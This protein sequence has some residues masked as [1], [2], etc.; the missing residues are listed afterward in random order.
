MAE[1][2][3]PVKLYLYDLSHGMAAQLSLSMLGQHFEAIYH[4]GIVVHGKEYFYGQGVMSCVP[5]TSHHGQPMEIVDLGVTAVDKAISDSATVLSTRKGLINFLLT[6]LPQNFMATPLG[7]LLRP[8]VDS[9]FPAAGGGAGPS[10]PQRAKKNRKPSAAARGAAES[11][12]AA[13]NA[14]SNV[15]NNVTATSSEQGLETV[16]GKS[17]VPHKD[18]R[19]EGTE[20]TLEQRLEIF[21]PRG[22]IFQD[23]KI[24]DATRVRL[25]NILNAVPG[26]HSEATKESLPKKI[27]CL[28]LGSV[29]DSIAP[30]F[31]LGYLLLMRE[32]LAERLDDFV[33][34]EAYDPIFKDSDEEMLQAFG[35]DV[36][37]KNKRGA[38]LLE[39]TTLVFMPHVGRSITERL[40]RTNWSPEGLSRL[41]Y[42]GND[43]SKFVA[44]I[45]KE[46][47]CMAALR[48]FLK[49]EEV[50]Q[51]PKNHPQAIS[52]ALND[53]AFQR[54][55]PVEAVPEGFWT[56]PPELRVKDPEAL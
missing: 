43:M 6:A 56:P 22:A 5:G 55:C 53:L 11:E 35:I 20:L 45:E 29:K 19:A 13:I 52:Y 47:P 34:V 18:P 40:I 9:A 21:A 16:T 49:M 2:E 42:C 51:L 27:L 10:T 3:T 17:K 54:F 12:A 1:L 48:P 36:L 23:P 25:D 26:Q 46:A 14:L 37:E 38:Y 33:P 30:Q 41:V 4:T 8:Q 50:P 24:R 31:Q 28:G 32:L 7:K 39:E 15:I 44:T